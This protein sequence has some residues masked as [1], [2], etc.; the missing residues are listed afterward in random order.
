MAEWNGRELIRYED[1][2]VVNEEQ[3][4]Q[5][6]LDLSQFLNKEHSISIIFIGLF[7]TGMALNYYGTQFA[8]NNY[9]LSFGTYMHVFGALESISYA[10]LSITYHNLD[11]VIR[12]LKRKPAL[13]YNGL[14]VAL[15][16]M[17]LGGASSPTRQFLSLALSRFLVSGCLVN[18][19]IRL[20]YSFSVCEWDFFQ[21]H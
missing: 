3:S 5:P 15:V 1:I 13:I 9:T 2:P 11:L 20:W 6:K 12:K 16:G 7:K 8:M 21:R 10:T 18:Y 17:L 19:N 14:T 4:Q